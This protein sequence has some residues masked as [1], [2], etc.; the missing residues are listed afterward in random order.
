[1]WELSEWSVYRRAVSLKEDKSDMNQVLHL[2]HLKKVFVSTAGQAKWALQG[3]TLHKLMNKEIQ[4]CWQ[5]QALTH[6]EFYRNCS[7]SYGILPSLGKSPTLFPMP[8]RLSYSQPR[9]CIFSR[10]CSGTAVQGADST[11]TEDDK[12]S[13]NTSHWGLNTLFWLFGFLLFY[14][15]KP[16]LTNPCVHTGLCTRKELMDDPL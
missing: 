10:K 1:M 15:G 2:K 16:L 5:P 13:C 11:T 4:P 3:R 12:V 14:V 6:H 8:S 7:E 9:W